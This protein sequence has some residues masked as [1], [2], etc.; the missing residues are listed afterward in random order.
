MNE[1][2]KVNEKGLVSARELHEFLEIKKDF[3]DWFKYRV[4]QYDFENEKDFTPILGKSTGGRPSKDFAV[5]IDMAKELSMLEN[6][7]KGK[8]ARK[9]FINCEKELKNN[10]QLQLQSTEMS[11]QIAKIVQAQLEEH[12]SSQVKMVDSKY[13]QYIR[14]TALNKLQ[15]CNYIKRRLGIDKAN[16]E[17]ELV[18]KR[19]MIM[20][21]ANKWQDIPIEKLQSSIKIID[22]CI[23]VIKKDRPY[24]QMSL[25]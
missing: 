11:N 4:G 5:T 23:D 14:P 9:Y 8:Q 24:N 2:I 6:N 25:F 21:N 3:T 22:E 20:L 16:D 13:S 19:I 10:N 18:K 1:L 15:I 17:Y 7:E 12:F